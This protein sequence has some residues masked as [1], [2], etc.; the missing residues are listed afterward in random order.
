MDNNFE[1]IEN[2][3]VDEARKEALG[4]GEAFNI[5]VRTPGWELIKIYIENNIR[6]FSNKAIRVGFKDM[7]EYEFERGKVEGLTS[8]L[9]HI[10]GDLKLFSDEKFTEPTSK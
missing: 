10:E 2:E 3:A 1:V 5:M 9:G 7:S 8:L 6:N 4:R